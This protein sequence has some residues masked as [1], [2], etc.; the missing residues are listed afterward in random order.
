ML[1]FAIV[2]YLALKTVVCC[3]QGYKF[4]HSATAGAITDRQTDASDLIICPM[5]FYSNRTDKK[6]D[7]IPLYNQSIFILSSNALL[8]STYYCYVTS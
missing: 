8:K 6:S 2:L 4:Y 1:Y 7:F 5:L 3:Q